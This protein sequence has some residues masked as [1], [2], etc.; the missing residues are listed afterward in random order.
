MNAVEYMIV[1]HE[2]CLKR[3][4]RKQVGESMISA[5]VAQ[6]NVNPSG[7]SP[8][9]PQSPVSANSYDSQYS[10]YSRGSHEQYR[11]F[12]SQHNGDYR[13]SGDQYNGDYRGEYCGGRNGGRNGGRHG[14]GRNGRYSV[15]C[16]INML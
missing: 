15:Q 10:S 5:N 2:A 14:R 3:A 6:V 13:D 8:F 16:Q 11:N 1:S 7:L 4:K 9:V 12:G